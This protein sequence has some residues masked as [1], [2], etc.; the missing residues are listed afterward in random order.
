M[1]LAAFLAVLVFV[2]T[3]IGICA[4]LGWHRDQ[5]I[6]NHVAR[7]LWSRILF[8]VVDLATVGVLAAYTWTWL[9]P[10]TGLAWPICAVFN[11]ALA[12]IAV[13]GLVPHTTGRSETVHVR[14]AWAAMIA[15][16]V[17]S[18]AV[19]I[20]LWDATAMGIRVYDILYLAY[21]LVLVGIA[22]SRYLKPWYLYWESTYFIGFF[23]LILLVH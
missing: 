21:C 15:M 4:R 16:A 23:A 2:I 20:Q 14:C 5:T 22:F 9:R 19:T 18:F 1:R 13:I 12:L 3:C 17:T 6:S 10:Q 7:T 11:L 8:C